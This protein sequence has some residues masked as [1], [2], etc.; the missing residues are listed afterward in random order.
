LPPPQCAITSYGGR[1]KPRVR[2][3]NPLSPRYETA[4]SLSRILVANP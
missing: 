3:N 1:D 2:A 4:R